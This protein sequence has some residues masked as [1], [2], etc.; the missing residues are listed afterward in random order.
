MSVISNHHS[1]PF[2]LKGLFTRHTTFLDSEKSSFLPPA[3][4]TGRAEI[5][6]APFVSRV[7]V[8]SPRLTPSPILDPPT[9]FM[10]VHSPQPQSD[11]RI[12]AIALTVGSVDGRTFVYTRN[13]GL[14]SMSDVEIFR[15]P[16]DG[17]HELV[18]SA[19]DELA[20]SRNEDET[21]TS[22]RQVGLQ[23]RVSFRGF[24]G[25]ILA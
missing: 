20:S 18:R 4:K 15:Q 7:R 5:W 8:T 3:S 1:S 24:R 21:F 19:E 12:I 6:P 16:P 25:R 13:P 11:L 14:G 2:G 17:E 22:W 9:S 10:R 23:F